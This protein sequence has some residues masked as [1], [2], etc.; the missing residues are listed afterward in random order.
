LTAVLAVVAAW[1]WRD[2]TLLRAAEASDVYAAAATRAAATK[3]NL[4]MGFLH[5]VIEAK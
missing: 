2:A 4:V 1:A 5:I 3:V